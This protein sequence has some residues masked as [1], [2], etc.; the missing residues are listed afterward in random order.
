MGYIKKTTKGYNMGGTIMDSAALKSVFN[1]G[2]SK[3]M[4]EGGQIEG[5]G[6]GTSDSI[7]ATV[8][9]DGFIVPKMNAKKAIILRQTYLG[10]GKQKA[11]LKD[12]GVPVKLSNGEHYFTADES[13]LLRSKGIDLNALAPNAEAGNQYI[14]GGKVKEVTVDDIK[15]KFEDV[16]KATEEKVQKMFPGK[17][18]EVIFSGEE[19]NMAEQ[20]AH[21]KAGRSTTKASTHNV[22]GGRDYNIKVDGRVLGNNKKDR[23]VYQSTLWEVAK[24]KGLYTL[25]KG[26][27]GDT[28]PYHV[29]LVEEGKGDGKTFTRL[30]TEYPAL[31]E[32]EET[33]KYLKEVEEYKAK[34][35]KDTTFDNVIN[36]IKEADIEIAKR[37]S[38]SAEPEIVSGYD[39]R[40][41]ERQ[42][43]KS[44]IDKSQAEIKATEDEK[45]SYTG[46]V[47]SKGGTGEIQRFNTAQEAY[48]NLKKDISAK[49]NGKSSWVKDDM[50]LSEYV[51]G[52]AP[53]SDG[54]DVPGYQKHMIAEINKT[55]KANGSTETVDN[56]S[57]IADI[58]NK[59]NSVKQDPTEVF[60]NAHQKMEDPK[61]LEKV[62]TKKTAVVTNNKVVPKTEKP[63]TAKEKMD[64]QVQE[65]LKELEAKRANRTAEEQAALA[66]VAKKTTM[67]DPNRK[68]NAADE[69][70]IKTFMDSRG[71]TREQSIS[72]A[73]GLGHKWGPESSA[74]PS[75]EEIYAKAKKK[76]DDAIYAYEAT[77][78]G[79]EGGSAPFVS[80]I[81][82]PATDPQTTTTS[83]SP[84][85][86]TATP[87][88]TPTVTASTTPA[89]TPTATTTPIVAGTTPTTA[90]G[91]G[92]TTSGTGATTSGG[93]N[94]INT[95]DDL[96]NPLA[97]RKYNVEQ[98]M[99]IGQAL[100]GFSQLQ[101]DGER[102]VDQL[103]PAFNQ[104]VEDSITE[105]KFGI[106]PLEREIANTGIERTRR[107]SAQ[108]V[109]NLSA[110]SAGTA[111]GNLQAGSM[112]ADESIKNLSLG[113][114]QIRL[115]KKQYA[116]SMVGQRAAMKKQLFN[117]KLNAFNVDQEAGA[118][119]LGSGI[120]NYIGSQRYAKQLE[121]NKEVAA[122][123]GQGRPKSSIMD[124][125]PE[126][127]KVAKRYGIPING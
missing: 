23:E 13:S 50:K 92:A 111:L 58:K 8:E 64:A 1:M 120:S 16:R 80:I 73:Q 54:N 123:T 28:D 86:I 100:L 98:G 40:I 5:P 4:S 19:R 29:S 112:V 24:E 124:N 41:F 119:L 81:D 71:V 122:I 30:F 52:F 33:K 10:N 15:A 83:T 84:T 72:I 39:P 20:Q 125:D 66:G 55:L 43:M 91:T 101:A 97:K 34:N 104:A 126:W 2:A 78:E 87:T 65:N 27:F 42:G 22:G 11:G 46:G 116:D 99:A 88:A 113:S 77:K 31:K 79:L 95:V 107:A 67:P 85:S 82:P 114:E 21:K 75:K 102:P 96:N 63:L 6:T 94:P 115:Q 118:A 121:S 127:I 106:S 76:Y 49:M 26:G 89:V 17:K 48:D 38:T 53:A 7:S 59:L 18:V 70:I 69:K 103:D 93:V 47:R 68:Y 90:T 117:E 57:S 51:S 105:S 56:D 25:K 44:V 74:T 110:G 12:G 9:E 14:K 3:G 61:V 62:N 60:T 45:G 37:K 109:M 36:G 108:N 35:P 32:I